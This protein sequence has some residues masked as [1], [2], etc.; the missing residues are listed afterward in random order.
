MRHPAFESLPRLILFI[1]TN[2][3]FGLA[4]NLCQLGL[5]QV[6]VPE[7]LVEGLIFGGLFGLSS[8]TLWFVVGFANLSGNQLFQKIINYTALSLL[9]L[10]AWL[11]TGSLLL[12][13]IFPEAV[14][15]ELMRS[16]LLI[17]V[18]GL[19]LFTG[20]I[21]FYTSS[22]FKNKREDEMEEVED[23]SEKT[24]P[25]IPNIIPGKTLDKI[26]V[27][28]GQKIHVIAI[29][30]IYF[31]QAEGDYVMIQTESGRFIKEQTMKYFEENL[32]TGQFVRIHRSCIVNTASIS[33]I[34]LYE[35]QN[36]RIT[37]H[38]GHQLKASITG[39]KLLKQY[40]QL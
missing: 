18:F 15:E 14:F 5:I 13:L 36:Y 21:C 10:I 31:L 38:S 39:Y 25:K 11:G 19:F 2:T 32:P 29:S 28:T 26:S 24:S 8:Y 6:S 33:R 40:L 4:L 27:K 37:L 1:G 16:I 17:S 3:I 23:L 22:A 34:E 30:D 20:A 35:K 9:M 7:L 12:Y